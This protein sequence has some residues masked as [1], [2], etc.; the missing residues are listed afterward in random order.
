M[1]RHVFITGASRGIGRAVA[2]AFF[3]LGD[4]VATADRA[5]SGPGIEDPRVMALKADVA[6]TAEVAAAFDQA[7]AAFGK[8]EV[9]VAVAGVVKDQLLLRLT[10]ADFA[11]VVDTNLGGAFRCVRRAVRSMAPTRR[12]SI[13]LIGSVVGAIG[14]VGQANYAASKAGLVGL[15][16]SAARELGPRGVTANVIAP[17]FIETD[18]TAALPAATREAYRAR[19]PAGRFGQA[20]DVAAAAVFLA[21]APYITGAVIPVDGGLG[22]GH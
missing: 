13:I 12:G 1:P 11:G 18:M 10:D 21:S 2:Q 7:E 15:A 14:G 6:S 16:R 4:N 22:M 8:V 9:L 20:H 19:I 3:D 17:G 5:G